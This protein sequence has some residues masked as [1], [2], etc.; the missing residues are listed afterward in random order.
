MGF[1]PRPITQAFKPKKKGKKPKT[2][3]DLDEQIA[4]AICALGM[5]NIHSHH[6]QRNICRWISENYQ[7]VN[8]ETVQRTFRRMANDP[9]HRI[10]KVREGRIMRYEIKQLFDLKFDE[11]QRS[12]F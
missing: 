12:L 10:E 1:Q 2:K 11:N 3:L 9:I 8:P 4:H 6:L 5:T 7:F